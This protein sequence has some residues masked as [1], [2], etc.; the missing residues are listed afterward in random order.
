MAERHR[1]LLGSLPILVT[2][3]A[4]DGA[5]TYT[6]VY[7]SLQVKSTE[8]PKDLVGKRL[9]EV[10]NPE[11]TEALLDAFDEVIETGTRRYVEFSVEFADE[12][13]RRG[14]YVAPLPPDSADTPQEVVTAGIDVTRYD[15]RDRALYDVFDALESQSVRSDLERAFCD[16]IVEG[17][18]YEMAWIGTADHA[19]DPSVRA[20]AYADEYLDDLRA[21]GGLDATADP[22][23]R[24]LRSE[25]AVSVASIASRNRDWAAVATDH[26]L[27]AA[28]ALPLSHEGVE[29]GVLAVYLADAEYLVP[30]REEVLVDYA[31]AVG[32]ALSAAMWRWA[33]ASDTAATLTVA[34]PDGLPLL[35][36]PDAVGGPLDVVSVVPRSGE[37]VYYLRGDD[38]CDPETA[39]ARCD[40]VE[41]YGVPSE[42]Q[43]AVVVGTETPES[44]LVRLGVRFHTFRV[45]TDG[46]TMT[47]IVPDSG[48]ARSVRETLQEGY[49]N[50]TI[51]VEWGD[52]DP[53][54][55]DPITGSVRSV[56]TDRQYEMLEAAYRHGYFD[57]DRKCNLSE[58]ADELGLSRWTVSEHLRLAQRT[59]CSHLLD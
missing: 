39:A 42:G 20:S 43:S 45:T 12:E 14:T 44:R 7:T 51:S 9:D 6:G 57:R 46:A 3:H 59:L 58:L 28:I 17:R 37:T 23:V 18:R 13:F 56:L 4:T 31:D 54:A 47:L 53:D 38:G 40:G 11:A 49:P 2:T 5:G 29:H 55:T 25:E 21:V 16:R 34:V 8:S 24:A 26:G 15:E 22:G 27:Q 1:R 52:A 32:Y 33:L 41:P 10:L 30:W 48:T 35:A 36:L 19:G 50:A